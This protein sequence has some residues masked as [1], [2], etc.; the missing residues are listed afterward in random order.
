VVRYQIEANPPGRILD[1][2]EII[3]A[4]GIVDGVWLTLI[5]EGPRIEKISDTR[6]EDTKNVN[7]KPP[8]SKGPVEGWVDIL[9]NQTDSDPEN[10]YVWKEIDI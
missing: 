8:D 6:I 5:P 1:D 3:S 4:A 2:Q 10:S 7:T 9:G